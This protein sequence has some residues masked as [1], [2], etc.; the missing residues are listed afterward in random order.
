MKYAITLLL[1]LFLLNPGYSQTL[2]VSH[3]RDIDNIMKLRDR[4]PVENSW[5]EWRLD[6]I[7]PDLLRREGMDMWIVMCREITEDPLFFS[8]VP[9]PVLAARRMVI[10]VFHDL[11]GDKGIERLS[12][13]QVDGSYK[14]VWTD[15]SKNQMD[16]LA[17]LIRKLDPKKI[18]IDISSTHRSADGLSATLRDRLRE[19]IGPEYSK[20]L[21]SAEKVAVGWIETR[22]PGE[23]GMYRHICGIAHDLI[24][25]FFSNGVVIPDVTTKEDMSWWI[26][27]RMVDIGVE[28]WFEPYITI[29]RH[30]EKS[31]LYKD[32]PDVIRRGDLLHCDIGIKYLGL[33]TD[34]QWNAYVLNIGETEV[35]PGLQMAM[36][37]A[38][39]LTGI[40]LNEFKEGL[41]GRQIAD[42]TMAK[43]AVAGLR[44]NLFS[45]PVG[46]FGH[47]AGV[48]ID[49]RPIRSM[50]EEMPKVM[51]YPL[52]LNTCYAIEFSVTTAV[53]EWQGR[54][55]VIAYE[56][57]AAFTKDGM[58]FIDGQ[59]TKLILIK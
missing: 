4:V 5:L 24:N 50:P 6:H 59:Q 38:V 57:N 22:S 11:G 9:K 33:C 10:L 19:S 34:M 54:D 2:P 47:S 18:G 32:N 8:L 7:I 35:S 12:V 45:H 46:I 48:S 16:N 13:G 37:N 15:R 17:D 26:W 58:H 42:N 23:L 41:N 51:E 31:E 3:S 27:Q 56:E 14:N 21:V 53:G 43:A 55:V 29:Q 44:V 25:E 39:R 28:P 36:D 20:R 1:I 40:Y 52:H 30:P 49:T